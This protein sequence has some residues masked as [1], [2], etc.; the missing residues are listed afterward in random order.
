MNKIKKG[1]M[2]LLLVLVGFAIN[3]V[4]IKPKRNIIVKDTNGND[5]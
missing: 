5:N 4:M 3:M 2:I 1:L